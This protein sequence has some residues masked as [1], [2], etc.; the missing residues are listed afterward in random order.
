MNPYIYMNYFQETKV[1]EVFNVG[2]LTGSMADITVII[3]CCPFCPSRH[4]LQSSALILRL[5][6]VDFCF[7]FNNDSLNVSRSTNKYFT[8]SV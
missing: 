1:T 6:Q 8:R 4:A 2:K 3:T 5:Y 7:S